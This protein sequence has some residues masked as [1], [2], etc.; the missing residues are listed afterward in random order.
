[1]SRPSCTRAADRSEIAPR[2]NTQERAEAHWNGGY[3]PGNGNWKVFEQ[4]NRRLDAA[5]R[6][7]PPSARNAEE[8]ARGELE[9]FARNMPNVAVAEESEQDRTTCA[10]QAAAARY[11]PRGRTIEFLRRAEE[12]RAP[13]HSAE[14]SCQR[15][16]DIS[17][18]ITSGRYTD[19]RIDPQSLAVEVRSGNGPWRRAERLS[20]GTSEQVYLLLRMG[21]AEHLSHPNETCPL[22][23]DDPIATS[24][25]SRREAIL[26][27]LLAV[28][29]STQVILFTHDA[30]T[31]DWARKRLSAPTGALREL[32]RTGIPA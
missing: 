8:R 7:T 31:R 29:E 25:A 19:C 10:R 24:D 13:G 4:R 11:Y 30:D 12:R 2:G 32:D 14:A 5:R 1:M 21:L 15:V 18:R 28:S 3:G 6:A 23:L 16:P 17:S 20:H 26:D 22:V 27:T 9:Q